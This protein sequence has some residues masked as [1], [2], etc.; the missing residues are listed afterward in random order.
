MAIPNPTV[1]HGL[2]FLNYLFQKGY[3]YQQLCMARSAISLFLSTPNAAPFGKS[4]EIRRFM[5]G[6]FEM[7]PVFPSYRFT[8]SIDILFRYFQQLPHQT[9]LPLKTLGKK[10]AILIALL[11]GGQR[12][13]TIHAIN[14]LHI[15]VLND[16]CIIPIYTP[17]K[18]TRP[19]KHMKPMEFKVYTADSKLCVVDNLKEYLTKTAPIRNYPQLFLSYQKPH[20]PVSVD[21]IS[22]W[23]RDIMRCGGI[24]VNTYSSHSCR[25]A[26]SSYAESKGVAFKT[27]ISSAGWSSVKTYAKFYSKRITSDAGPV[28]ESLLR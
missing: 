6:V 1:Y 5:K 23:C 24:D 3:S 9:E 15:R 14:V 11:A 21:T 25:A 27:I 18:Q 20:K 16:K 10:L 4:T 7:R 17:L 26:A 2:E 22:R 28:G 13:Q 12:C 8:W 19:G